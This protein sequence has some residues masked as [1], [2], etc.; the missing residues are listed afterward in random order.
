MP[1]ADGRL[2]VGSTIEDVGFAPTTTPE[3]VDRLRRVA[4]RLLGALT[5]AAL[6][7]AWA[8]LRPGSIDG[9][10]TLGRIPGYDNAFIAAGHFR[11]GLHQST[12]TA[13][14]LADLVTGAPLT[15]D[16]TPFAPERRGE[17]LAGPPPDSVAAYLARAASEEA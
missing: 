11:A 5:D 15:I 1:R 17:R 8:G 13:V 4:K 6:E 12:G 2:L 3:A 7:Q 14:V 10:P 16:L 9:L